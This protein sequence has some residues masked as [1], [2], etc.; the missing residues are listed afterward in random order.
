MTLRFIPLCNFPEITLSVYYEVNHKEVTDRQTLDWQQWLFKGREYVSKICEC[1][2]HSSQTRN[3]SPSSILFEKKKSTIN[4]IVDDPETKGTLSN[5][6]IENDIEIF[7]V[8]N[9]IPTDVTSL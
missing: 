4:K 9:V 6:I 1:I 5:H 2:P 7:C 8:E 3:S